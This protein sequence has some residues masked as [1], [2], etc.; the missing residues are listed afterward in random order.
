M[1]NLDKFEKNSPKKFSTNLKHPEDVLQWMIKVNG[2]HRLYIPD[3]QKIDFLHEGI[4]V[5]AITFGTVQYSTLANISID[6]LQHC[7]IFNVPIEGIQEIKIKSSTIY[8]SDEVAAIFSPHQP[9]S[10]ILQPNCQ[11]QMIRISKDKVENYLSQLLGYKIVKP[12]IF[13]IQA[14][15]QGSIK[16]WFNLAMNFQEFLLEAEYLLDFQNIWSN[17][18]KN[19]ISI[20][21]NSQPHNYSLE[22]EHRLKGKPSYLN[23]IEDVFKENLSQPITL[24]ELEKI[25]GISREKLYQ[26]FNTYY[27]Q[28]PVAYLRNLRFEETY[29]RL[30][31]IKP[32]ENVSSI[33]MDCGFQQLGRFSQEYKNR[34]GELPSETLKNSIQ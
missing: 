28:S 1:I 13:D 32:W 33:A 14:P 26:D 27:G 10:M 23:Y 31:N 6:N 29:K 16:K 20:L 18:E 15:M 7:Y 3:P 30:K 25:L 12:L 11:K 24:N 5:G 4:N 17:F 8:S 22:L 9:F 34:F 21:L 2:P 19:L